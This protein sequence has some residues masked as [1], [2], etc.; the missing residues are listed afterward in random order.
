MNDFWY[1]WIGLFFDLLPWVGGFYLGYQ[2][3]DRGY[4]QPNRYSCPH[5]GCTFVISGNDDVTLNRMRDNH[6]MTHERST[7]A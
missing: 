4:F 1:A 7:N 5:K 3:R 6:V 2:T